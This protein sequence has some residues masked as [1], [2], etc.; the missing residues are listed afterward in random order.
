MPTRLNPAERVHQA[1]G[2]E[3]R[4]RVLCRAL[5]P[6]LPRDAD[7]LDVGCGDGALAAALMAERPDVTATGIDVLAREDARVPVALF[8][9]RT[10][11]GEAD[12]VDAV[13]FC[14]VLHHS[15]D[16]EQLL[17]EAARVARRCVLI[18]DHTLAGPLAGATLR[19]MDEVGNRRFGVRR[20]TGY[21]SEPRWRETFARL[22]LAIG[23]W[24]GRV[25]LY[26]PPL[27]W[28]FG[29]GLHFVAR[30]E[31]PRSP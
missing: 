9:G 19:F 15:E 23:S 28:L 27:S 7:L 13:L 1:W 8:D 5:A 12:S 2:A 10:L 29:R 26:P 20:P 18:K 22:G 16:P 3:R 6:L 11:P 25:P 31:L 30:L 14:D 17:V 21:W 24:S 4:V